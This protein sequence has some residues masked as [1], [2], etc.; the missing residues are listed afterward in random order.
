MLVFL[1]QLS[2]KG[3]KHIAILNMY[4]HNEL[5]NIISGKTCTNT[6][7]YII[8]YLAKHVQTQ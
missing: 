7:S 3:K 5:Y 8:S 4:K 1:L 6:M 2:K